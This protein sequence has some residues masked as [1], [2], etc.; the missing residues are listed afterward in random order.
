MSD[1]RYSQAAAAINTSRGVAVLVTGG[2]DPTGF[3]QSTE[4]FVGSSFAAGPNMTDSREGNT[5]TPFNDD[6]TNV[7]IAGGQDADGTVLN[8]AEISG[9]GTSPMST[10]RVKVLPWSCSSRS[11]TRVQHRR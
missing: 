6:T 4:T 2:F 11:Q 1:A 7:L 8:S 3:A 10:P 9:T 5:A